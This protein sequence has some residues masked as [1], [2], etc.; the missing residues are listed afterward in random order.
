MSNVDAGDG[1]HPLCSYALFAVIETV[2]ESNDPA[3]IVI[4]LHN[5]YFDEPFYSGPLNRND[6]DWKKELRD[7][8]GSDPSRVDHLFI[9]LLTFLNNFSSMQRCNV[10]CG[11]RLTAAGKWNKT[12][13]GGNPKFT[14]FRNNPI[15]L[16]ENKSS[17]PVRILAELRHQTPSFSDSDGLNHYHQTGLVLMQ[18]VH[19]KMA[20]T[21][22]IT[23]GTHRFIQKGMM[24]DAREVCSQMELPPSTT[25]YLIPYTMKRGCHGKFNISV[26]P[27]MAKVTLTPL[28]YAGLKREPLVVDFVLK[29]GFNSSSRV[30][31]QVSDPCDVHVLL[32][33]V[34]RRGNVNPLVD[35]LADDAVKLT[36]FDN[37]GIKLASTGD[38]TNAREQALVLQL[39]KNC[40]LNFV[41]ER[42][43]RK[44]GGDCPCSLYFFTPP[45]ILAKIVSLPP[46]N[47]VAAKPGV[48]VGGWTPR[49]VSTSSCESADFQ[50]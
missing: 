3:D 17:R 35:F 44:G 45:N 2:K 40:L 18:S 48:A 15:Y 26:Y 7:V 16:V 21:P 14:T 39:S 29:S 19:A 50:N 49:G 5:C 33:Q 28:R 46:L 24:L 38:A 20:P 31:L 9:P 43:N 13:C 34:K 12:S 42:V 41:A 30:S 36:V 27:G 1:I 6:E 32:G 25:C 8:C 11:D 37:Y 22:L 23:S 47:P 10:N 4:K